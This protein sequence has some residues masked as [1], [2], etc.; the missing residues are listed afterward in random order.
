MA[1]AASPMRMTRPLVQVSS[2]SCSR[3]CH[4]LQLGAALWGEILLSGS[5]RALGST[6]G[7]DCD[8]PEDE[9]G[10]V[11]EVL[12]RLEELFGISLYVPLLSRTL[13]FRVRLFHARRSSQ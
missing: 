2:G 4:K 5:R 10:L 9:L 7:W 1:W 12:E 6:F 3:S 11:A 8:V 13:R